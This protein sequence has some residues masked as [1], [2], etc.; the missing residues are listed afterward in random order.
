MSQR[1]LVLASVTVVALAGAAWGFRAWYGRLP[2]ES[3][4][5]AARRLA[6]EALREADFP[7][8]CE[9][10]RRC[11]ESWPAHAETRFLLA[12]ASR[13][14]D[15]AEDWQLHLRVAE[16]LQWPAEEV[17]RERYLMRAQTGAPRAAEQVIANKHLW[18]DDEEVVLEALVKGFLASFRLAD[19]TR[20]ATHWL[21]RHPDDWRPWFYR[22][23]TSYRGRA[24][25]NAV[26]DY[27][28]ALALRPGQ[29]TVRAALA[30]ALLL[31]GQ[32][33][34]ALPEYESYVRD[35]PDDPAGQ[36][37]LGKTLLELNRTVEA[38]TTLDR[39][40]ERHP[41]NDAA[42]LL[43]GR[44]ELSRDAAE[45]AL[46]W[47]KR[48]EEMAPHDVDVLTALVTAYRLLDRPAD[49]RTYQRRLDEAAQLGEELNKARYEV[50][51]SP[52]DVAPRHRAGALCLRLGQ[53]PEATRWL[54]DALALDADHRPSHEAL[55]ECYRRL[56]DNAQAEFHRRRAGAPPPETDKSPGSRDRGV[57][58]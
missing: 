11:A 39:L 55:A 29:R 47:L 5:A 25:G 57:R 10:L 32:F 37:G 24:L 34:E 46:P 21:E 43:R 1:R 28:R 14:A 42:L 41:G 51:L 53:L 8:A 35:Y 4:A 36:L 49:A 15:R 16:A 27:R 50:I 48:A 40:L 56:G 22:G 19:A 6:E 9:H 18:G 17:E 26:V 52:D 2:P 30:G 13:R 7:K 31:D 3:E 12:R 44:L 33:P 45:S 54:T 20:W 23:Q 38:L 58:P